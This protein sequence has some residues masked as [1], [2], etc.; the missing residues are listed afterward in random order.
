MDSENKTTPDSMGQTPTTGTS[1]TP[2][3]MATPATTPI[4]PAADSTTP[5]TGQ[6]VAAP[7][8][9]WSANQA[10]ASGGKGGMVGLIIGI[11]LVALIALGVV[12]YLFV[13]APGVQARKTSDSFM[14]A[15]TSGNAAT[16]AKYSEGTQSELQVFVPS[17]QGGSAS[18]KEG[19]KQGTNNYYLYTLL[20]A[21]NKY[22]RTT[23]AKVSGA[24][25]VTSF[26]T[27]SSSLALIPGNV[28]STSTTKTTNTGS[29]S[30]T[31]S[32]AALTAADYSVILNE[33]DNTSTTNTFA[34]SADDP[35]LQNV[36][37]KPDSLSLVD[38]ASSQDGIVTAFA[39]FYKA[40]SD[41]SFTIHLK[42]SVATTTQS[43]LDFANQRANKVK[44]MLVANGV[45]A[46]RIVVD[47]PQNV[48]ALGSDQTS[49]AASQ[50]TARSVVL[51]I[52][53]TSD[54]SAATSGNR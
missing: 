27:S 26:V 21:K 2:D 25:K 5:M 40:K 4:T 39:N 44:T 51:S 13:L 20:N 24:W 28:T 18:Y 48:S 34:Y 17:V 50:D 35:F 49:N 46:S 45:P 15:M 22:A 7:Q 54:C 37:F 10:Q 14:K 30:S 16:A 12:G 43:D 41:K 53:P 36:H 38:P 3:A 33:I 6:P 29:S 42:G 11:V 47:T 32:C 9:V 8:P 19:A 23:V 31:G 1:P 52:V